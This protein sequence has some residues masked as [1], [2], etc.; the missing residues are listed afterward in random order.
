MNRDLVRCAARA[1]RDQRDPR[2]QRASVRSLHAHT[3]PPSHT[4]SIESAQVG[5]FFH[6]ARGHF[7]HLRALYVSICLSH[8]SGFFRVSFRSR[9]AS[10]THPIPS[11]PPPRASPPHDCPIL[12][13]R[14]G[15]PFS[16]AC[17]SSS[18]HIVGCCMSASRSFKRPS[19]LQPHVV[20]C[21]HAAKYI[22]R[23]SLSS[24]LLFAG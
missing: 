18:R 24:S 7:L 4:E 21:L 3:A 2:A 8:D 16:R 22:R 19:S 20:P 15:L 9:A 13:P 17:D 5:A 14:A 1:L 10:P 12:R 11:S 23:L 6:G